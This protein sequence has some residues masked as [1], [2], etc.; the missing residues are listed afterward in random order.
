LWG[1][2]IYIL[3]LIIY[4]L[5]KNLTFSNLFW[6]KLFKADFNYIIMKKSLNLIFIMVLISLLFMLVIFNNL[7]F[8]SAAEK[9]FRVGVNVVGGNETDE[10]VSMNSGNPNIEG[11]QN[12]G[13]MSLKSNSNIFLI[14]GGIVVLVLVIVFVRKILIRKKKK[15]YKKRSR[16][17][18]ANKFVITY[19]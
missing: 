1:E 3:L 17:K 16:K 4:L 6:R 10:I 11:Q 7:N 13:L 5:I 8:I 14:I 9:E 19:F 2:E 18:K 15:S 12:L